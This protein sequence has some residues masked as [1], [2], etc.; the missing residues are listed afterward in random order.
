MLPYKVIYYVSHSPNLVCCFDPGRLNSNFIE[1]LIE[2][3]HSGDTG[4]VM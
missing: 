4:G 1:P 2:A 3:G